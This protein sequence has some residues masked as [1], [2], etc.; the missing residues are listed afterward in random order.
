[1][2]TYHTGVVPELDLRKEGEQ[3]V[4]WLDLWVLDLD[5][6]VVAHKQ[7]NNVYGDAAAALN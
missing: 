6:I 4:G 3:L 1:M 7:R 5:R 2:E